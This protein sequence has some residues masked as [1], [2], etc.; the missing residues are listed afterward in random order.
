MERSQVMDMSGGV[1]AADQVFD[2][3]DGVRPV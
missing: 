2:R 1:L 3:I